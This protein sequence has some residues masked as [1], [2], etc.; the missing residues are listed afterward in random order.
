MSQQQ[1]KQM[2]VAVLSVL[3]DTKAVGPAHDEQLVNSTKLGT[4]QTLKDVGLIPEAEKEGKPGE[5]ISGLVNLY[6]MAP[7]D[8]RRQ[9]EILLGLQPSAEEPVTLEQSKTAAELHKVVKGNADIAMATQP[10][11]PQGGQGAN[12]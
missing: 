5:A 4:L 2:K 1:I 6:K 3:Q 12:T 7:P 11:V 9:I 8:I 10:E